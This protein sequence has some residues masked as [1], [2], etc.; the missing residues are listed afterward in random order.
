MTRLLLN[1]GEKNDVRPGDIVGMIA[2]VTRLDKD[3]VG[4]IHILPRQSLV[5]VAEAH[6]E[7]IREK[8]TGIRFKGRKLAA[9]L[10]APPR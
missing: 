10:A 7:T 3:V 1:V 4:A 5:D 8:L 6:E 9:E 2:G